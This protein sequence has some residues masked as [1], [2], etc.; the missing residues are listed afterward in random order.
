M[1]AR[2]LANGFTIVELLVVAAIMATLFGIILASGRASPASEVRRAARQIAA[3]LLSAQSRAIGS[4]IGAAVLLESDGDPARLGATPPDPKNDR[5]VRVRDAEMAPAI[6]AEVISPFQP[7]PPS[8][9]ALV[10]T[11]ADQTPPFKYDLWLVAIPIPRIPSPPPPPI[12]PENT[13]LLDL[14]SGFRI[15]FNAI[16]SNGNPWSPW[17]G[18]LPSGEDLNGNGTQD[19]GE[20]L[21]YGPNSPPDGRFYRDPLVR[22]RS[23]DGQTLENSVWPAPAT[24]QVGSPSQFRY[25]IE[26]SRYPGIGTPALQLPETAA[27]DLRY[28]GHGEDPA[29]TSTWGR[30]GSKGVIGLSFDSVGRIDLLMQN[31]TGVGGSRAVQPLTP[32]QAIYFF[33]VAREDLEDELRPPGGASTLSSA[34]AA[35]LVIDP[36]SGRVSVAANDPQSIAPNTPPT[37]EQLRAARRLARLTNSQGD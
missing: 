22:F 6:T 9:F 30:L 26:V 5:A 34:R 21:A 7:S 4:R 11:T 23:A 29:I 1:T 20:D 15:R 13:S 10:P 25:R 36:Q 37:L 16:P 28:S 19:Q 14:K 3:V 12:V 8:P 18:F 27:I 2:R 32:T 35:W 24:V 33:V 31:V 17:Y